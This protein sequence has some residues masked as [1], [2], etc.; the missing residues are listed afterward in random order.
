MR[1]ECEKKRIRK[2]QVLLHVIRNGYPQVTL[3]H[4]GLNELG[5]KVGEK[6]SGFT[7]YHIKNRCIVGGKKHDY[8]GE[9]KKTIS[10]WQTDE[11]NDSL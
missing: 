8:L 11:K 5:Y 2:A 3:T 7:Y 4:V 6:E 10:L 9:I 1:C